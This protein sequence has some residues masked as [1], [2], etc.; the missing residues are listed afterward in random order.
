M[1]MT[2]QDR[3]WSK[4]NKTDYCWIWT[5]GKSSN[6]YGSFYFNDKTVSAH[7]FSWMLYYGKVIDNLKVLHTCDNRACVNPKHL[8]LGTSADN[9]RDMTDRDRQA[10]GENNGWSK[11]TKEQIISIKSYPYHRGLYRQLS[12][13]FN[14]TPESISNVCRG[15]YWKHIS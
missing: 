3:F 2:T 13:Q 6:G 5:T 12:K 7:K 1:R 11:L 15:I 10:K 8:Y 4:V 9:S 14:V